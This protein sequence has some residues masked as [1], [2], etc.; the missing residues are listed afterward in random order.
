MQKRIKSL[1]QRKDACYARGIEDCTS[2]LFSYRCP[3][4]RIADSCKEC[5]KEGIGLKPEELE[6]MVT[7]LREL[8]LSYNETTKLMSEAAKDVK[9]LRSLWGKPNAGGQKSSRL[10][11]LGVSLIAFPIPTIGIKKSLGAILIAAGLVQ[12]R[13]KH[14]HVADVYSTFQDVS[15]EIQK[16]Q[17]SV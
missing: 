8:S 10:I 11:K 5:L 6:T 9:S 14:L 2:K 3:Y 4:Y 12:E 7:T 17:K 16:L 13:M 1:S 15:R